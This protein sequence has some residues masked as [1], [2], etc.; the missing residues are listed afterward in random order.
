[1]QL[2][3]MRDEEEKPEQDKERWEE[4]SRA[5]LWEVRENSRKEVLRCSTVSAVT[6]VPKWA[7]SN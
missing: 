3:E 5:L 4:T 2:G 6:E 1:M 7:L